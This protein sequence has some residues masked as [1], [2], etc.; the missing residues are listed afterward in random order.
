MLHG[1]EAS[2]NLALACWLSYATRARV[3]WTRD[4]YLRAWNDSKLALSTTGQLW[5][6]LLARVVYNVVYGPWEGCAWWEK[7]CAQ[8]RDTAAMLP[9]DGP[10]WSAFY[11]LVCDDR[12][13]EPLGTLEHRTQVLQDLCVDLQQAKLPRMA[14]NRWFSYVGC[15]HKHAPVWHGRLLMALLIGMRTGVYRDHLEFPLWTGTAA[16]RHVP[17]DDAESSGEEADRAG[18]AQVVGQAAGSAARVDDAAHSPGCRRAG[19]Q[20]DMTR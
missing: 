1:D 7:M 4:P 13:L 3:L 2:P 15:V 5:V 20:E 18:A 17:L 19:S 10:V 12:G 14:M 16:P 6:S 9:V 11:P 8:T